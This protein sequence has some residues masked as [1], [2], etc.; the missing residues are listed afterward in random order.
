LTFGQ[1]RQEELVEAIIEE[2]MDQKDFQKL[3][4][5]LV[6][7]LSPIAK[8]TNKDNYVKNIKN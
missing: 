5:S 1:P 3:I 2:D 8:K 6:I 7:N 4:S